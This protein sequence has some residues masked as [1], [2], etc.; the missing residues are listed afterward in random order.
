MPNKAIGTFDI[1]R[2]SPFIQAVYNNNF[3]EVK[4]LIDEGKEKA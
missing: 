1:S 4:R 2:E 3:E